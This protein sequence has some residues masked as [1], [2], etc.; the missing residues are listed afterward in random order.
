[1]KILVTGGAGYLGTGLVTQLSQMEGI[2]EIII[3]DNLSRGSYNLFLGEQL[4]KRVKI[5]LVQ[6]DLL[7]SRKLKKTLKEIDVVYHLAAKVNMP[8][9]NT[10]GH[11]FE[12]INHWG[13]AE[14]VFA[15]E[16]SDVQK[17]IYTSSASVYGSSSKMR[18]EN[19]VPNPRTIYAISKLRGEEQVARLMDKC[20][21]YILR[22]GNIYGYN[23]NIRFDMVIN[24][25]MFNAHYNRRISIHGTGKQQRAFVNI[26]TISSV[27][28]NLIF[29][30]APS[31]IYNLFDQNHHVLDIVD[32]L[33]AMYPDLEFIFINQHLN[34]REICLEDDMTLKQYLNWPRQRNLEEDLLEFQQHFS[35]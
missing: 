21:T 33:K 22:C 4:N 7:D 19:S 18:N 35:F 1:M 31:G 26:N 12:Q 32:I 8:Y 11:S 6:G 30:Q 3:Y 27:L 16:E 20:E 24:Q 34:L 29:S 25:F 13:T 17:F 14:L 5:K 9:V 23:K 2:E 10:D 28:S 15:I